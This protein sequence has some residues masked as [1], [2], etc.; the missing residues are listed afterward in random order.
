MKLAED[1]EDEA[2]S[3][4]IQNYVE[5]FPED[6]VN[7]EIINY[8][9]G[10]IGIYT[11]D[12]TY[13]GSPSDVAEEIGLDPNDAVLERFPKE[14]KYEQYVLPGGENYRELLL[15]L[16]KKEVAQRYIVMPSE[17][18]EGEYDVVDVEK[19]FSDGERRNV[20][21]TTSEED[22]S[23]EADVRNANERNGKKSK[24]N[25]ESSHWDEP[26]I[27]AHIRM[28]D[29]IAEGDGPYEVTVR[30]AGKTKGRAGSTVQTFFT[31]GQ[32][33]AFIDVKKAGGY[34]TELRNLGV[35]RVLFIEEIQSDWG[36][37]GKLRLSMASRP[38]NYMI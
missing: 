11:D 4:Y 35:E 9:D 3:K 17:T 34:N 1:S 25:F 24:Y 6:F 22:A 16:P 12:K 32:A 19:P 10:S 38:L 13:E 30:D 28:D 31:I 5:N 27:L 15:T 36:Q 2:I 21:G 26:N 37:A 23:I 33:N 20:Y 8:P 29:R 14:V 7:A 18:V